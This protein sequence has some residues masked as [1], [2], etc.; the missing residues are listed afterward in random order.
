MKRDAMEV[1]MPTVSELSK[2]N[3]GP[4][5]RKTLSPKLT[6]RCKKR[7]SDRVKFQE[8]VWAQM[9]NLVLNERAIHILF[10]YYIRILK[11][12]QGKKK[13]GR[14]RYHA[15]GGS[16]ICLEVAKTRW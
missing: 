14:R 4:E 12:Y 1:C 11:R 5:H 10:I 16:V 9:E 6:R 2:H 3:N 13:M 15:M 7:I 8:P